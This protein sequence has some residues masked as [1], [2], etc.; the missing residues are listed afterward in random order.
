MQ[1]LPVPSQ[2]WLRQQNHFGKSSEPLQARHWAVTFVHTGR[3]NLLGCLAPLAGF[4]AGCLSRVHKRNLQKLSSCKSSFVSQKSEQ[5][6]ELRSWLKSIG[7]QG[8]EDIRFD[9]STKAGGGLAAFATRD[10]KPGEVVCFVPEQGILTC[11]RQEDWPQE[12][13]LAKAL[14]H[15]KDLGSKSLF[16]PYIRCLP[17]LEE[18]PSIHPYFWPADL[19]IDDLLAG[20]A[21]GR[22]VAKEIFAE[23]WIDLIS[24]P[25]GHAI[26]WAP[27]THAALP[28]RAFCSKRDAV[29]RCFTDQAGDDT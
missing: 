25:H 2:R 6:A 8:V 26:G 4:S 28:C 21:H 10:F 1:G 3:G 27:R 18:L 22:R 20:S 23:G 14:L 9:A 13:S 16:V 19:N 29:M 15:E 5:L 12:A 24:Q 11:D 7:T 17:T